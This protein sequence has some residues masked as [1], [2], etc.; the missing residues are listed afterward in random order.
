M[1]AIVKT[2]N[3]TVA[4]SRTESL[5]DIGARR[6]E[7]TTSPNVGA[8]TLNKK[9]GTWSKIVEVLKSP[10]LIRTTK[11]DCHLIKLATYGGKR[12]PNGCLRSDENMLAVNGVEG[13]YDEGVVPPIEAAARLRTA[14]IEAFIYTTAS[15]TPQY[16]RW[17][18]L[19]P[20]SQ[21]CEPS[22]RAHYVALLNRALEGILAK[23]SF[24]PS[25]MYYFGKVAGTVY[26]T[27]EING[28]YIDR[29]R[30][31]LCPQYSEEKGEAGSRKTEGPGNSTLR[32]VPLQSVSSELVSDLRSALKFI[33]NVERPT[34]VNVLHAL[35]DLG[36]VGDELALEYSK[37]DD[38]P[39]DQVEF[40]R[41]WNSAKPKLLDYRW[42]F[43]R[44][45]ENG[46]PNPRNGTVETTDDCYAT[47]VDRTDTGTAN[48]LVKLTDGNLRWVPERGLWLW[49][50]ENRW[51]VDK[52]GGRA[53]VAAMRVAQHYNNEADVFARKL[54][55][56][57]L[58]ESE[59]R[60]LRTLIDGV[61]R[62]ERHCRNRRPIEAM[63]A[64]AAKDSGVQLSAEF[65]DRSPWLLGVEN[66][67][68]DLRTGTLRPAAREDFVTKRSSV[69][70]DPD[71]KAPRWLQFIDEIT[72]ASGSFAKRPALAKYLQLALGYALTG[73][74]A[75][76][77]M[78]VAIG[79]GANGKNVLLDTVQRV[80][81]DYWTTIPAA[82]LMAT[83]SNDPERASPIAASLSGARAAISSESKDGQKLDVALVKLHTGGGFMTARFLRENAFS[84][85][86]THKLWLMTNHRPA[87]DHMD[88]A[89]RGRL[90]LIPFDRKWNRPGH[91]D[92]DPDLPDGDKELME[93]LKG[94][95]E[96]VLA[97]L[98]EGAVAYCQQGL[99]PPIE[100][101]SMTRDYFKEE[102]S[103]GK[104]L[105]TCEVCDPKDGTRAQELFNA[106]VTWC[107]DEDRRAQSGGSLK[108]FSVA[109]K[110]RG[111][112]KHV[113]GDGTR[114]GLRALVGA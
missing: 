77:K 35:K 72:S 57:A 76:H 102:D 69:K 17:R 20:L 73:S 94:E 68:V 61:K 105:E 112:E 91:P 88:D 4:A 103:L 11:A 70:F 84:F 80:A 81:G 22:K 62:W 8:R 15:H 1:T 63:L 26:E 111:Y 108:A 46:W 96:G 110:A 24:T 30:E 43:N 36:S 44:A 47:R 66:G 38:Y 41:V 64:I 5:V 59:R 12:S 54:A 106:Y 78:F 89:M 10:K 34:W 9:R 92:R 114:Y 60:T 65:L 98:T 33:G 31:Q 51:V 52:Q 97:W 85:D 18:V 58:D 95:E 56:G 99:E 3:P 74:T 48:L 107:E 19:A 13:D 7:F 86:I 104:W 16:P 82:A 45:S 42:I 53:H 32:L 87:L 39:F 40:S 21:S 109:V 2:S 101:S 37:R 55:D 29:L 79:S 23:E 50:D 6:V 100:V 27:H 67:V 90:H 14:G 113:G 28:E 75:E 25:Q 83:R 49:W 71:A 93:T